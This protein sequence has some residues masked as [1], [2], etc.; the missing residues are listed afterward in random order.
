MLQTFDKVKQCE[1]RLMEEPLKARP[2]FIRIYNIIKSNEKTTF[3]VH[4]YLPW[5]EYSPNTYYYQLIIEVNKHSPSLQHLALPKMTL[6]KRHS[7]RDN[8][9]KFTPIHPKI[10]FLAYIQMLCGYH[11]RIMALQ[12]DQIGWDL[13]EQ[14]L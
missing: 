9:L 13:K 6:Q 1:P 7:V 5:S 12:R 11:S 3:D 10:R 14:Y 4:T 2:S 8:N